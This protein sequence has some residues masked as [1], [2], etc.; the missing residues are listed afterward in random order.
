[1]YSEDIISRFEKIAT[2]SLAD[3]CDQVVQRRCF[4]DYE[5]K[6]RINEKKI[7]GS[8][9]TILEGPAMGESVG[10]QHA[11]DAIE[12]S[13]GGE[14]VVIQLAPCDRDVALWGGIMT[15]GA[16][17]KKMKGA[18]LDSGVRDVTEIRRDYDLPVYARSISPGTTLGRYKS[19]ASNVQ[20]TCGG[21]IV[22]AGDLIVAD[23]DGVVCIPKEHVEKVLEVAEDIEKK[24]ALQAKLIVESGSIKEGL[25]KYNR[26]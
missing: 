14:I 13:S 12:E 9:I 19:Y 8:A 15:A 6:N 5:I 17:A 23:I 7:V 11:I 24:E 3:A 20:I 26:I 10:P 2:A 1:M 25:A 4:M 18:I 16:H 22:N 21:V